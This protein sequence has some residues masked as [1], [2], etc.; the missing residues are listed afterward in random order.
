MIIVDTALQRR[1]QQGG[2]IGAI[3]K[4]YAD[5][6]SAVHSPTARAL[7]LLPIRLAEGCK[8]KRAISKDTLLTF[9]DVE[10]PPNRLCGQLWREQLARFCPDHSKPR[11]ETTP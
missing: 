1:E 4:T 10:L 8:L 11:K 9:A 6:A 7:D 5:R 3:L 2:P